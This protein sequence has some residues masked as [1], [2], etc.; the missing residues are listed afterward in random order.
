MLPV[1]TPTTVS[2]ITTAGRI[3]AGANHTCVVLADNTLRCWG[4]NANS[5]QAS[6]SFFMSNTPTTLLGISNVLNIVGGG[7]HSCLISTDLGSV[8]CF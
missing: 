4:L 2:G 3:G 7:T 5:Q 8:N 1:V 6:T